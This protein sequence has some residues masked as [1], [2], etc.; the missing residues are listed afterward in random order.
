MSAELRGVAPSGSGVYTHIL[1]SSGQRWNGTV[2]ETY[3]AGN[4]SNYSIILTEQ[5]ASGAFFA[6]FPSALTLSGSYEY[7]VYLQN[8]GS[9]AQGDA[10]V[11][12]GKVNWGGTATSD[13]ISGAMSG[14]DFLAYVKRIFKRTDKDTELYDAMTDA[15]SELRRIYSFDEDEIETTTTDTISVLGDYRLDLESN[16]GILI[17]D[18]QVID[19]DDSRPVQ[20]VAK[21]IFDI[22]YPNQDS[23]TV[24][25]DKPAHFAVFDGK[26]F[27]GPVPDKT[28]YTYRINYSKGSDSISA[29]TVSVP[30]TKWYREALREGVLAKAWSGLEEDLAMEHQSKWQ[31]FKEQIMNR[32][33]KNQRGTGFVFYHGI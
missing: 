18:I 23:A 15:I 6:D 17:G 10:I 2:F 26:I 33:D 21:Q 25:R 27:L 31:F 30:F 5:G 16:L 1:N 12:T 8:G 22:L 13:V 32:E 24:T 28:S 4:Y 7:L 19:N 3:A 29:S 14:I 11:G 9:P 20:K